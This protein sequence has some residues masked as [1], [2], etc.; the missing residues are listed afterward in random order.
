MIVTIRSSSSVESSPALRSL[1]LLTEVRAPFVQIH[2]R[3]KLALSLQDANLLD[4]HVGVAS[5]DAL[6]AGQREHDLLFAVDIGVEETENVL[7]GVLVGD[8][9]SH[10]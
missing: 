2:V 9:E 8:D 5:T 4:D 1:V 7:E 6:D 3:L 10:G